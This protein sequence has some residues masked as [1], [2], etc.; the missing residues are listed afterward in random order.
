MEGHTS[1]CLPSALWLGRTLEDGFLE[2]HFYRHYVFPEPRGG[3][4]DSPVCAEK[5]LSHH[6]SRPFVL[7][8][9]GNGGSE[10]VPADPWDL[11]Q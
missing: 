7:Y 11:G 4:A 5:G 8:R 3:T 2:K 6:P 1:P 9:G 10:R